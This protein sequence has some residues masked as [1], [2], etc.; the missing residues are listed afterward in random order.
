VSNENGYIR[1]AELDKDYSFCNVIH[2]N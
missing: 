1:P 2:M